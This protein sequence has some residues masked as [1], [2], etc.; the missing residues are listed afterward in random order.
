MRETG[1]IAF[2]TYIVDTFG[3]PAYVA[4]LF[5]RNI[6]SGET[7]FL[8][9]LLSVSAVTAAVSLL[10]TVLLMLYYNATLP[11]SDSKS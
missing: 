8:P 4:M 9:L 5:F 6:Q 10:L 1:T 11:K 3:Y 2:L 7:T